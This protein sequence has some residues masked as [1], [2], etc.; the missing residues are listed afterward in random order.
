MVDEVEWP[1][2]TTAAAH[3]EPISPGTLLYRVLDGSS[4]R[5]VVDFNPGFGAPTRFAFITAED[6]STVPVLYAALTVEAALAESILRYVPVEGGELL[7]RDYEP[8]ILGGLRPLR[9][10]RLASFT[11]LG[12]RTLGTDQSEVSE[13]G[14]DRY[15]ETVLWAGTAHRAGFDGVAW[16]NHRCNSDV[17]V[18]LFGDRVQSSDLEP[19]SGVARI[20]RRQTD[21]EWL[22]DLC[23]GMHITVRW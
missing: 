11:G 13:T 22:T 3:E 4:G 20:F 8:M 21:R 5:S 6:G 1:S 9:N 2:G 17:A 14:P 7:R 10:L 18:M 12:L 19:D 16:M 23:A 15:E